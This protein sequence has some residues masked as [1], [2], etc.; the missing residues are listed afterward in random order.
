M[1]FLHSVKF[2][3]YAW[4]DFTRYY[5]AGRRNGF[6]RAYFQDVTGAWSRGLLRSAG[7]DYQ[8]EGAENLPSG[9]FLIAANHQS[10]LDIPLLVVALGDHRPIFI[11]KQELLKV[12]LLGRLAVAAG[13]IAINRGDRRQAIA[14]IE[15]GLRQ[16]KPGEAVMMFPEGTRT[17]TGRMGPA[18]KGVFYFAIHT[19]LPIAP[20]A[21]TGSFD[22]FPKD[23]F[24]SINPGPVRVQILP[25]ICPDPDRGDDQV[26]DLI[27]R[28]VAAVKTA[29]GELEPA[30]SA[31][32]GAI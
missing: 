11:M 16:V 14:A 23:R 26:D 20:V 30:A 17:R 22:R 15:E 31:A 13:A 12:P 1:G 18:K 10:Y 4:L 7:V 27:E 19:G 24:F 8:V 25:A 3:G 9:P 21:I 32:A 5:L 6:D 29:V 2:L 28:W